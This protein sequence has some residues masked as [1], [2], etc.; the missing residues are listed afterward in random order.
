[1]TVL[2]VALLALCTLVGVFLGDLLGVL[3][4]VKANVGGVGIAMMLLIAARVWLVRHG[5]LSH[6]TQ[7]G[8]E[9]WATMYIPIVVAMAAQ[10]NVVAAVSGGPIVVIAAVGSV[11][12]CFAATALLGRLG[13]RPADVSPEVEHGGSVIAGDTDEAPYPTAAR[14]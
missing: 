1:M 3:L 5:R 2:G 4:Q 11:M 7:L 9:F 10:Q 13:G 14:R 8:V 6:A 12:L